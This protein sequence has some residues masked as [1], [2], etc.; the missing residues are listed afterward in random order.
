MVLHRP[1]ELAAFTGHL[2]YQWRLR[3]RP[4]T[5]PLFPEDYAELKSK[6]SQI[7]GVEEPTFFN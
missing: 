5:R 1:V 3:E 2:P 6:R 7:A 4:L